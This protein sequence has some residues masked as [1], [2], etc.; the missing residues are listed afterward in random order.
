MLPELLEDGVLVAVRAVVFHVDQ[1]FWVEDCVAVF[2]INKVELLIIKLL[3]ILQENL[4]IVKHLLNFCLA[5][6][7]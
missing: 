2:L 4:F 6:C 5:L 1:V 7:L 3:N